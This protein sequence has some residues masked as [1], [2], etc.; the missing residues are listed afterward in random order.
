MAGLNVP[1]QALIRR[2]KGKKSLIGKSKSDP[3]TIQAL[4]DYVNVS[5]IPEARE[6]VQ[7][8]L[9]TLEVADAGVDTTGTRT[10]VES[11]E[12]SVVG[13][14]GVRTGV[15]ST[16]DVT[17]LDDAGLEEICSLLIEL[18]YQQQNSPIH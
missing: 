13:G 2:E 16:E 18:L 9:D 3:E 14:T 4:R 5:S 8:Y 11:S 1:T 15:E 10:G 6:G 12:P 7:S 17:P